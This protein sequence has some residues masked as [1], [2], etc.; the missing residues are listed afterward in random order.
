[1]VTGERSE[2]DALAREIANRKALP[3]LRG[4]LCVYNE[5]YH[6]KLVSVADVAINSWGAFF[7]LQELA[8]PGFEP[9]D[10]GAFQVSS[11]WEG[12]SISERAV[13]AS[14]RIWWLLTRP[15]LVQQIAAAAERGES[16]LDLVRRVHELATGI[17]YP[18]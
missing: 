1:M 18:E 10:L 4:R 13:V 6:V 3:A 9:L 2:D 7:A 14:G 11:R 16:G 17:T 15:E 8:A 12:L 5:S